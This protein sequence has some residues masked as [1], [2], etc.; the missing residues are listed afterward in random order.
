MYVVIY[1]MIYLPCSCSFLSFVSFLLLFPPK[2][3]ALENYF[4]LHFIA[5]FLIF[6]TV[7]IKYKYN[8]ICIIDHM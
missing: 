7:N 2:L 3:N 5:Y 1:P 6:L 8:K 4:C